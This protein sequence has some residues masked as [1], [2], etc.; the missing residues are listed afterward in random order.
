[1]LDYKYNLEEYRYAESEGV[2]DVLSG[3]WEVQLYL[4]SNGLDFEKYKAMDDID[5][6]DEM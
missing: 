3:F 6:R 1:L 5:E 4:R 2:A